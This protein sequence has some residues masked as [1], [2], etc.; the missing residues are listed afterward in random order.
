MPVETQAFLGERARM[1]TEVLNGYPLARAEEVQVNLGYLKPRK[2]EKILEIGS[3]S[4][5]Y[6]EDIAKLVGM[7][8]QVAATDPSKDQL[9]NIKSF[10][11]PNVRMIPK[12]ADTLLE[13]LSLSSEPE[14]FDA[15]W[16]LGAFHHCQNKSK[17]FENFAYLLKKEARI[18]ICD[19][20]SGSSLADYFDAEVAKYSIN[21]HEVAFLTKN[22]ASSLCYL[23]HFSEPEF[24]DLDYHW[25]FKTEEELGMFMYKLHGMSMTTPE[26]CLKKVM[27]FMEVTRGEQGYTLH[28]PLTILQ[29]YKR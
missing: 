17:A 29:T 3:G 12:G 4:G 2:S 14:S 19:V 7:T 6:T 18:L 25:N 27:E 10:N 26:L 20:F 22:F 1:Y 15:I 13:D 28:V 16:S 8:G 21:G 9:E 11:L 23:F 5:L 24:Y